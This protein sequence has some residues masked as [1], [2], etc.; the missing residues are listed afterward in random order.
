MTTRKADG[1]LS[2]AEAAQRLGLGVETVRRGIL[3]G[4]LPGTAVSGTADRT[5]FIIPER[6]LE[7][8]LATGITPVMLAQS[9]C[10]AETIEQG[11]SIIRAALT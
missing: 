11:V 7:L 10:K 9:V 2:V 1:I 6:A 5:R 4:S 8:F 3:D